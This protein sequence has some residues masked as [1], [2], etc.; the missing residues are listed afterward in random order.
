MSVQNKQLG[1][2]AIL[3]ALFVCIIVLT[4]FSYYNYMES[5][6]KVSFLQN[7]KSMIIQDLEQIQADLSNLSEENDVN[8][9]VIRENKQ[10]ITLLI[11]SI[12]V[13]EVDYNLL[14]KYRRELL[15][16]RNENRGLHREL[17]S[18]RRENILLA[19][20]IDSAKLRLVELTRYSNTLK[21]SNEQLSD[22]SDSLISENIELSKE[23][24]K[25]PIKIASLKA[26]AYKE[27]SNG[28]MLLTN[29]ISKTDRLRVCFVVL[30]NTLLQE[31]EQIF[32]VQ[33]TDPDGTIL[34]N[35]KTIDLNGKEVVYSK[36]IVVPFENSPLSVCDF[37]VV[38]EL[39]DAGNYIVNVY[40][41]SNLLASSNFELK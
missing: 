35:N 38:N 24:N 14:H 17:D 5:E 10:R 22:F 32:Y 23:L 30:P 15:L 20:E 1:Q 18:V 4:G 26:S 34:G 19:K 21:K 25:A 7:E 28:R 16:L 2:K 36:K 33:F 41:E 8:N 12:K 40:H 3:I 11:D 6:E 27:R 31:G 29:R 13:L 39:V 9:E 37:I